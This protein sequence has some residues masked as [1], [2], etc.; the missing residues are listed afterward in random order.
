MSPLPT[1]VV[2]PGPW[3]M[4]IGRTESG[5]LFV[6]FDVSVA[7][8]PT[9]PDLPFCARV[10]LRIQD[11]G[12]NGAP[13]PREAERLRAV[14][15]ALYADLS[16][17]GS[18]CR[19]VARLTHQGTQESVF[20]VADMELFRP[21]VDRWWQRHPDLQVRFSL[22]PG[23]DF[24]EACVRPTQAHWQWIR[25]RRVVDALIGRGS[26][27]RKEH[28]LKFFFA[29]PAEALKEAEK[30]LVAKGYAPSPADAK[31]DAVAMVLKAP[32]DTDLIASQSLEHE[33]L[34]HALGVRYEGWGGFV[35]K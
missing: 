26:D 27:P 24:Y 13:H 23:W 4:Y 10:I 8:A 18:L 35:E 34:A 5:P 6:T 31:A 12:P 1:Q 15:D 3:E 33:K 2:A 20:M 17:A 25:D 28:T 19:L 16:A 32:L 21:V 22:H 14:E 29:G 11:A 7:S 30:A 9:L